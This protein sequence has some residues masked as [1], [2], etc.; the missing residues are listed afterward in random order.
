MA[1]NE[2][3]REDLLR[4]AT[5]L[6]DRAELTVNGETEPVV[7]GFR[8][9]GAASFY[10]GADPVFQFN[11]RGELR[12][13]YLGGRLLKAD[14]GRLVEMSRERTDAATMLL[15]RPI[16][17]AESDSIVSFAR[18]RLAMLSSALRAGQFSVVGQVSVDG[19][20]VQRAL[21]WLEAMPARLHVAAR[22]NVGG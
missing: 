14:G 21:D 17:D 12:R 18:E 22:P 8:R 13:G 5:A 4:E 6:V 16:G 7:V 10:F 19:R 3:D 2:M 9:D 1:R 20:V 15:S 11:V